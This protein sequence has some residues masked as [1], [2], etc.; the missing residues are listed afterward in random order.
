MA[1]SLRLLVSTKF[2]DLADIDVTSKQ[3][4]L[5]RVEKLLE[6]LV[7]GQADGCVQAGVDTVTEVSA[8]GNIA[9]VQASSVAGDKLVF[10]MPGGETVTITASASPSEANGTYSI[11]T[12][13]T[14]MAASV[15][16]CINVYPPLARHFSAV[17]SV[18][19]CAITVKAPGSAGNSYV[20]VKQVTTSGAFTLTQVTGGK[21][22]SDRPTG[23]F[24][25]TQA[26][27]VNN[28][29]TI[30]G[31]V[32]FTW[33]T[34]GASGENQVN[35][36]STNAEAAT[37][38]AAAINAHSALKQIVLASV[39]STNVVR[40]YYWCGGREGELIVTTGTTG[41]VASAAALSSTTVGVYKS[42]ARQFACGMPTG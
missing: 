18:G 7:S 22:A 39:E 38:L 12:S 29:T 40:M 30:V 16:K 23:T 1:A 9:C 31:S 13:N 42:N 3:E 26:S 8:A 25:C 15:A 14:V 4:Y 11:A 20:M 10:V 36:G 28:S 24:T 32:T 2:L 41:V 34:S 17:A 33:K 5:L 19:N 37:N 35:I 27:I 21:D 6:K